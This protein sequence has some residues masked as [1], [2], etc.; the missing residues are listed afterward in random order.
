MMPIGTVAIICFLYI[1]LLFVV[2]HFAEKRREAG[3]SFISNPYIYSLSFAVHYNA[4]AYYGLVGH[5]ANTGIAFL[6]AYVGP[7]LMAFSWW[8]LLRKMV[9]I[10]K[11]QNILSIADFVSSRYGNSVLLGGIVTIFSIVAIMPNLALQL[12]AVAYTFNLI[13]TSPAAA[14]GF[15]T[16]IPELPA[17]ADTAFFVALFLA[18]FGILFGARR[19]DASERHEG[20]MAAI[21]LQS[22]VKLIAFVVVGIFVTYG[23]FDGF[24]DIFRR[25]VVQFPDRTHL[26]LLGTP[27]VSYANW[28]AWLLFSMM[29][30]MFLPRQ[31]HVMVIENSDEEHIKKAMWYYPVYTFLI[32]L[33]VMPIALGGILV[34]S[35]DT[36]TADYFAIHLPLQAGHPWLAML[37]FIGGF[38]ASAGMVMLESVVLSTMILNYLVLPLIL[39]LK[40]E[41]SDISRALLTIKRL[42][43]IAVIFL[44][45]LYYQLIGEPYTLIN[46]GVV[47]LIAVTQFAPSI[48]GGLYW[49]R[50]TRRGAMIGLI[51]GFIL[52]FYTLLL[53]LLVRT[54]WFYDL[55][56]PVLVRSG[57][58][59]RDIL[60]DGPF[61]IGFLRP[62]ELFGLSGL[63]MQTHSLFWTLFFNLGAFIGVSLMTDPD[64][65]EAEQ[66]V[67][68]V[69]VFEMRE[70]TY[71]RERM[72]K[73]PAI[74]EFV[75]LMTKFIGEKQAQ[76]A[77]AGYL[78]DKQID[79][80][81]SLSEYEL[82]ILKRYTEKVLAGSVGAASAGI[83]IESYMAARGSELED[84]F[85]IFG[86]VTL[87]RTASR[88]QLGV[89]YETARVVASGADLNTILDNILELL[90]QQFKFDLSMIRILDEER[91]MLT[92]R[93]QKG[94]TWDPKESERSL[95]MESYAGAAFLSNSDLVVND[96]DLMDKP[97]SIRFVHMKGIKSFAHAPISI[98]GKPIGVLSAYSESARGMF[99]D[100]FR[101]LFTMLAGQ[102]GVAWRN[103]SQTEKLIE[104]K[105]QEQ[106]LQI[107][108]TIQLGLLP[109]HAPEISGLSIAGR[110]VPAN[111]V[112]GDYYDFLVRD[113]NT[114][115][116]VIADVSGHNI[117]AALIMAE[118]RTFIQA[119]A[120]NVLTP[121]E[122]LCALNQFLYEDL[123]RAEFFISMFY[124]KFDCQSRE[125]LFASAGHNPPLVWS[126]SS[127][128]CLWLDAEGLLLG[129]KEEVAFEEK[130]LQLQ[131]GDI[132]LLYTDGITEAADKAGAFFG[133]NRL[134]TMLGESCQLSPQEIIDKLFRE[135]RA[136][137]GL[138]NFDDD[139]TIVVMKVD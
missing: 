105:K 17:F 36:A 117:G 122:L 139:L 138:Q 34:N 135:V 107:A 72:I 5:A 48:I 114:L 94:M 25:F 2:A 37:V 133:E 88:E 81:G 91:Q 118:A 60:Q 28:I 7:T 9:R 3:K 83:I 32:S 106:E 87:G 120:K 47:S 127:Q 132:L 134:R 69:D 95:T 65:T 64:K 38:S 33:F 55:L 40:R 121:K 80:R 22:V 52:W 130:R 103:A 136:F 115:D 67:K 131:S 109:D 23:L 92:V 43:I 31:F 96:V 13:A 62:L 15:K 74:V 99:T 79:E 39:K 29:A 54:S 124:L 49:K 78:G 14:V 4:W 123:T 16:I 90:Q 61:G 46:I 104:A 41:A 63:D 21:A 129:V 125:L 76:A 71:P 26:F 58:L 102:I 66:A 93:N 100:E 84:V 53:P 112:G 35:G 50:A 101:E 19:L 18:L 51:L 110:C 44:G 97:G 30:V 1:G 6:A 68:F 98:E 42:G 24:T 108:R 86:S 11:E 116:L 10:S 27:N 59:E 12:K 82:P 111:D 119:T 89:L 56:L 57:W 70:A 73:A 77:I 137:T 20:L 8:F 126:S 85:D 75:D 113:T 45:Y 128:S